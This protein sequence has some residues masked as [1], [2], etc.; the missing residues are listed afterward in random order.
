MRVLISGRHL[1]IIGQERNSGPEFGQGLAHREEMSMSMG[2][3][4]SISISTSTNVSMS[5]RARTRHGIPFR[6]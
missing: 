4:N 6:I 5:V 2:I 3:D 1:G